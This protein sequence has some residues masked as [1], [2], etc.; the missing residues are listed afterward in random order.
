[1][2]SYNYSQDDYGNGIG[3]GALTT[4]SGT[5]STCTLELAPIH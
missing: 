1:M 2:Y 4:S 5:A 3:F